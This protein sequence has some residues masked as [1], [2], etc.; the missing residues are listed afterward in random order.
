[1]GR[2]IKVS[3][4][5]GRVLN[6]RWSG[7]SPHP[8]SQAN[9]NDENGMIE[10]SKGI[11][12]HQETLVRALVKGN[13]KA[14]NFHNSRQLSVKSE[15]VLITLY[16]AGITSV[17]AAYRITTPVL[18]SRN[19]RKH[20]AKGLWYFKSELPTLPVAESTSYFHFP[21]STIS[22][23]KLS[24]KMG[25]CNN[26]SPSKMV[27]KTEEIFIGSIDQGTTSSRFLIFNKSGEPVASHQVEFS[28][29]YPHPGYSPFL[30]K[31]LIS[32]ALTMT[33]GTNTIPLRS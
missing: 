8:S 33:D 23:L 22:E 10:I 32:V 12:S 26:N 27:N 6:I 19:A 30:P 28:Q 1:M 21:F 9:I 17:T 24:N 31:P 18:T 25:D 5:Y 11:N 2:W 4:K 20:H 14:G 15:F 7:N 29:I 3:S 13:S 16:Y